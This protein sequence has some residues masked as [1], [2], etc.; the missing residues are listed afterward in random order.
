MTIQEQNTIRRLLI[1]IQSLPDNFKVGF[2]ADIEDAESSFF[3]YTTKCVRC[4]NLAEY[5]GTNNTTDE[6][7]YCPSCYNC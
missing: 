1:L 6:F 4:D 3:N 5:G 7:L 2:E